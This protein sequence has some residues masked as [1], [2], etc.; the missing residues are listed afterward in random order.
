MPGAAGSGEAG[1]TA[2]EHRVSS[3]SYEDTLNIRVFAQLCGYIKNQWPAHFKR[4]HFMAH[5]LYPNKT[6]IFFKGS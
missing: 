6:A 3:D 2:T 4:V 5:E 1:V